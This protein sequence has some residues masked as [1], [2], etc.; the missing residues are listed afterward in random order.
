MRKLHC[1]NMMQD[2]VLYRCNQHPN[3]FDCPDNL[4]YYD[5]EER[6]YG[7]IVH[8]G[9]E[10]FLTIEYCPWCGAKLPDKNSSR[11]ALLH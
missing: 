3:P 6:K 5:A 10:S 1:C 11:S 7:L 9:G 4:I 8:D 2:N